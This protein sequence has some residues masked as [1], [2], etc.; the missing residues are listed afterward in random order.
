M[1]KKEIENQ[2]QVLIQELAETTMKLKKS[3]ENQLKTIK[4]ESHSPF[5]RGFQLTLFIFLVFSLMFLFY[6]LLNSFT[7]TSFTKKTSI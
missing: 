2:N 5:T 4:S 3:Y 6:S 7:S 1:S